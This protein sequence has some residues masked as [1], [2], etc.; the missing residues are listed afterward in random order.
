ME[1]EQEQVAVEQMEEE[2]AMDQAE[3]MELPEDMQAQI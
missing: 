3:M 1:Q 2:A